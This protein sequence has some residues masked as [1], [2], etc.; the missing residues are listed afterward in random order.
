MAIKGSYFLNKYNISFPRRII[1]K[2][3]KTKGIKSMFFILLYDL[4]IEREK[5]KSINKKLKVFKDKTAI[6]VSHL[7]K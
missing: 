4:I 5:V 2:I 7:S 6:T 1:I 3:F